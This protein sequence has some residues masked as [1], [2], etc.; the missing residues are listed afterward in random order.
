MKIVIKIV[1]IAATIFVLTVL[2]VF[3]LTS[4]SPVYRF[5]APKPFSGDDIFNPYRNID[6]SLSWK[7]ANFHTHTQV[8]GPLN[9]CHHTP[10]QVYD[11]LAGFGYD[12]V[13]FSNHNELTAHPFDSSLQ[14]NVYEHGYNL[15][16]YHKLVFG[17]DKVIHFDNL[18][19]IFNFQKQF[20]LDFLSKTCDFIQLNHPSRTISVTKRLMQRLT[21]YRIIELDSGKTTEQEYWDW[22]LSAGHYSFAL[23][24]DDL[25]YPD[26]TRCTAVRCNFLNTASAR[27]RD[28]KKTLLE[29]GYYCMRVP[30]FGH[31]DWKIKHLKNKALA[32]IKSIGMQDSTIYMS[33]SQCADSIK[34]T[35]QDHTTLKLAANTDTISYAFRPND[36]YARLTAYFP[37]GEVIYSN[38]FARYDAD[39]AESPFVVAKHAI[40]I[41]LTILFNLVIAAVAALIIY[42][43]YR[44]SNI[45]IKP[46]RVVIKVPTI[47]KDEE[48]HR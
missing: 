25:H 32:R 13:T 45:Q 17:S 14:V 37:D 38:P 2:L 6:T 21:G 23:A 48:P 44:L 5:A 19:P 11:S 46:R 42:A 43:I 33:V 9:E 39:K 4:I 31:G 30:D 15:F 10:K 26:R 24:N 36:A 34:V 27:Y 7:R 28:I 41:P 22:A 1:L 29:G 12:I 8:S 16:K 40:D 3:V 20:Q 18:L 47:R 35:G